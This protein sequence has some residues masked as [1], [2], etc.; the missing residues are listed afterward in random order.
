MARNSTKPKKMQKKLNKLEALSMSITYRVPILC[1]DGDSIR[2][3]TL[4]ISC[5]IEGCRCTLV[6]VGLCALQV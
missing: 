4:G 6:M 5:S 3:Y 2:T 1:R